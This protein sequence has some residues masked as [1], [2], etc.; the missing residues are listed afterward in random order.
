MLA[1][2]VYIAYSSFLKLNKE[3]I[4]SKTDSTSFHRVNKGLQSFKFT[5]IKSIITVEKSTI[6]T[7]D[8]PAPSVICTYCILHRATKIYYRSHIYVEVK[9]IILIISQILIG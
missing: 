5:W 6:F 3:F 9:P 1:Y 8:V 4:S 7:S 2:T